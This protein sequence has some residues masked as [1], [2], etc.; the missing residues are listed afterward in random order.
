MAINPGSRLRFFVD[1]LFPLIL[2]AAFLFNP[3]RPAR[4]VML[5]LLVVRAGGG[6]GGQGDRYIDLRVEDHKTPV[7]ELG[8]LLKLHKSF[9]RSRHLKKPKRETNEKKKRK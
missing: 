9:F 8:R 1:L 3:F 7:K 5:A 4:F 6:Y 2:V